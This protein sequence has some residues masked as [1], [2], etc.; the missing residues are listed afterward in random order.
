MRSRAHRTGH[1][2]TNKMSNKFGRFDLPLI[3]VIPFDMHWRDWVC[4]SS[5]SSSF[6][7][8]SQNIQGFYCFGLSAKTNAARNTHCAHRKYHLISTSSSIIHSYES[9]RRIT[10]VCAMWMWV[11]VCVCKLWTPSTIDPWN[12]FME[13]L[14]WCAA[15]QWSIG[16]L[17]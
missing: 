5:S 4:V 16:C 17:Y 14:L 8:H 10:T 12:E 11:C 7:S 2:K 1:T 3:F 9:Y 15:E 6:R 13:F